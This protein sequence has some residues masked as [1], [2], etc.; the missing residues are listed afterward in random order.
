[1]L[2][3]NKKSSA[4]YQP[5]KNH[6]FS[7]ASLGR[8]F[9][10]VVFICGAFLPQVSGLHLPIVSSPAPT[11]VAASEPLVATS[12]TPIYQLQGASRRST[13]VGQTITT[14]GEVIGLK[15]NGFFLQ[16]PVSHFITASD[17]IFVFTGAAPSVVISHNV[18][19]VGRV[20]EFRS[21]SRYQPI[22]EIGSNP[23]VT[24]QGVGPTIT[25]TV[26]TIDPAR[27]QAGNNYIRLIP[28]S[29]YTSSTYSDTTGGFDPGLNSV[30]LF[31]SVESMLVEV[32]NG[33][34]VGPADG[35]N[36]F[37]V[38]PDNGLGLT[39]NSRGALPISATQFNSQRV[40]VGKDALGYPGNPPV[41][42]GDQITSAIVGPLDSVFGNWYIQTSVV[43][44]YTAN[45]L[46]RDT[47][48]NLTNPKQLRVVDYNIENFSS[49]TVS[50]T[51]VLTLTNHIVNYL[52]LPD[53]MVLE[54]IQDDSGPTDDGTVTADLNLGHIRDAIFA[55]SGISYTWQYINPVNNQD[56]G[57]LGGN[58]RVAFLFRTDRGLTFVSKP[59]GGPTASDGVNPDGTLTQ[60]P[61]RID[62]TNPAFSSTYPTTTVTNSLGITGTSNSSNSRKPLAGEFLFN[63]QRLIVIGNHLTSRG[64]DVPLYGDPQ[65]ALLLSE[66]QRI[67]QA[68]VNRDFVTQILNANPNANVIVAGDMNAFEFEPELL[69]LKMGGYGA[70]LPVGPSQVLTDAV[71][72]STTSIAKYSYVFEGNAQNLDH[73]FYSKGLASKVVAG[74][75]QPIH[76]N[77]DYADTDPLRLSDHEPET[78]VFD[79]S[80]PP[81][82]LYNLPFL[83]N[84][85]NPGAP[86]T[87]TFTSYL[88]FQNNGPITATVTINYFDSTGMT[89][90]A[91]TVVTTVAPYGEALP[92]NPF[93]T[94]A[95]GAGIISSNQPLNV[96]V[97]EGT[98]FG[99]SAY[100]V[101]QGSSANLTAPLAINN[102]GG[103][104]TQ[105]LVFNSSLVT[106]TATVNFY[107]QSGNAPVNS[108]QNITVGP[109]QSV[110]LDQ[111][112]PASNLPSGFYGWAQITGTIGSSLVAQVLEQ[113]PN[114]RFVAIANAQASPKNTLYAP[115][116]FNNAYGGFVTGAN[117]VNPNSTP[118]SVSVTYYNLS[119]TATPM[120]LFTLNG[121]SIQPIYQGPG[122]NSNLPAGFTGAAVV[123]ATGGGVVMVVNEDNINV[124]TSSQSGTYS[125]AASGSGVVGLPVIAN[126][127]FGYTTGTTVFN[128]SSSVVSF[129]L[130]YYGINGQPIVGLTPASYT[131]N[132]YASVGVFQGGING[133]TYGTA[134][135]TQT[136]GTPNALIDTT[137]A[138]NPGAGL[139]Y[140]YTEPNQ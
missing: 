54:E 128:A 25:P 10:I 111:T 133:L 40:Q 61:G 88:A 78:V 90:T 136:G 22:T 35:F 129:T 16:N 57:Q 83:G 63:G 116:I 102:Q 33:R 67:A 84:Q 119:G 115:A 18:Q 49:T 86:I 121:R 85:Y 51:R 109:R 46:P 26:L 130:T 104:I 123:T 100:A 135:L 127:G 39:F 125:A 55:S 11:A 72:S 3:T 87:G 107:D 103:F 19:V 60:S 28:S 118:V 2:N 36:E 89:L 23:V 126:G 138:T 76:I 117:I 94:G 140:T 14:T 42:V 120:P 62:P 113:S 75:G 80:Q 12:T 132:Q 37:A 47:V 105:L 8:W 93:G 112:A 91:S 15:S 95:K 122:G 64:G 5:A 29:I 58:I 53:L 66:P 82:Y 101:S 131:L 99:G 81:P 27:L 97:A 1:M 110:T 114:I 43:P 69:A 124:T 44:S 6:S 106:T 71:E 30:D 38:V 34:V 50:D 17:G 79:F 41:K 96:I 20:S 77:S 134:V 70:S 21:N 45:V 7:S 139:F 32:D 92:S 52:G 137:N 73:I 31:E 59:G 68:V 24:D 9:F 4:F 98:P 13:F 48:A 56:G 108:S 74:S 65:P